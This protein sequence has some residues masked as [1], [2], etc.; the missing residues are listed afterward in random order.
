MRTKFSAGLLTFAFACGLIPTTTV[1]GLEIGLSGT[2]TFRYGWG[3]ILES[4]TNQ[5]VD[6]IYREDLLDVDFSWGDFRLNTAAAMLHPAELPDSRSE[7]NRIKEVALLRRSLSWTGPVDV[8]V[9]HVWTSFGDGLSLDLYRDDALANPLLLNDDEDSAPTTWDS[10]VDGALVEWYGNWAGVKAIYGESDYAGPLAGLNV[11]AQ[12]GWATL[13]ASLVRAE[14]IPDDMKASQPQLMDLLSRELYLRTEISGVDLSLSH[15]DQQRKDGGNINAGNGGLATHGVLGTSLF[16]WYLQ[17]EYK[18]Y[19]FAQSS[20]YHH[21]PPIAQQEIPTRLIA[22]KG[23]LQNIDYSD[24]TGIQLSLSRFYEGGHELNFSA[25][26]AS[27]IDD[28]LLPVFR[29]S[30]AAYQEYIAGWNMEFDSERHLNLVAAY[31]E[32]T[33]GQVLAGNPVAGQHWYRKYGLGA[34]LFRPLPFIGPAE[35]SAEYMGKE[36]RT[37]GKS[38]MATLLYIDT[39]PLPD[40]SLNLTVDYEEES[41]DNQDWIASGELRYDFDTGGAVHHAMTVFYGRLRKGLVCSSGNCREVPAF[42]GL[43]LTLISQF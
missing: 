16:E 31:T 12:H 33:S 15:V 18:Y 11:E 14:E 24:E 43:K 23:R 10:R 20:L 37:A 7:G 3:S 4:T 41:E 22:R 36:D 21:N 39:V 13:G 2:N 27:R 5:D 6:R 35:I 9:G 42:N 40:V 26:M 30:L 8:S 1:A 34:S 29:E 25:A 19:R 38:T 28:G 32:E 17:A